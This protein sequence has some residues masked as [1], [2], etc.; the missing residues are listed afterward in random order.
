MK[1]CYSI[2]QLSSIHVRIR[3]QQKDHLFGDRI[4]ISIL[5]YVIVMFVS[6]WEKINF[7]SVYDNEIILTKSNLKFVYNIGGVNTTFVQR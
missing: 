5:L 4:Y 1:M 7:Y 2:F 6:H 3:R